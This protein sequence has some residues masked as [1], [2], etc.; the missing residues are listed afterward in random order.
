[1]KALL[2]FS[3]AVALLG[4]A[5]HAEMNASLQGDWTGKKI[6]K[7]EQCKKFGGNGATPPIKITGI[8]KGTVEIEA[9]FNDRN[10]QPLSYSGGHG[11]VGFAVKGNSVNLPQ[12]P[13]ETA[14]KK[15]FPKGSRIIK[16]S[17]GRINGV[18]IKGYL[19]PCSGGKNNRYEVSLKALSKEGKVLEKVYLTIGRY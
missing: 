6:P 18:L 19:P 7:G 11:I 13:G 3:T 4:S 14:D 16:N 5:L 1:M 9:E 8:P 12:F 17:R 10:N 2:I 15:L